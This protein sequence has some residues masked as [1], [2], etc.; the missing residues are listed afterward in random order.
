MTATTRRPRWRA[1]RWAL[2]AVCLTSGAAHAQVVRYGVMEENPRTML[3]AAW[4]TDS[5]QA[6]RAYCVRRAR[7][8]ARVISPTKIDSIFHILEVRPAPVESASPNHVSFACHAGTPELHTH[9][10]ATCLADDPQYCTAGGPEAYSCQPSRDDYA[11]LVERGDQ[12]AVIQCDRSAF[13]FYYPS[14]YVAPTVHDSVSRRTHS[15]GG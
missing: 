3:R 15:R 14:E 13:R 12:F 1:S 7:I 8:V 9:T 2:V 6:E 11:K 10:P 4:R 5:G